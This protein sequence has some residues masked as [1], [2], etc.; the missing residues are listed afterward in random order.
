MPWPDNRSGGSSFARKG[1]AEMRIVANLKALSGIDIKNVR[2]DSTLPWLAGFPIVLA[3]ALLWGIPPLETILQQ[4]YE[5]DLVPY[6]P[7]ILS[8]MA[9]TMPTIV[10]AIIGFLLLDQR[11]D[12]TLAALQVTPLTLR[13]YMLY[14]AAA[15]IVLSLLTTVVA[16]PLTGLMTAGFGALLLY[17]VIAAPLGP[18]FALFV[19]SIASNKVQGFAVMKISGIFSWPPMIAWFFPGPWQ[20]A[21]GVI[22]HY[23][24]TKVV[25]VTEAGGNPWGY[26]VVALAFQFGLLLYLMRHF[27][28]VACR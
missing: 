18:I 26:V 19:A 11:D 23:W 22:P 13:G 24:I 1:Y 8:F 20:L 7:L 15:P 5:F 27:E 9:L 10:G 25:W 14:R 17:A 12:G 4:R 16:L 2:R 6:H 28:R 21:F 3:L